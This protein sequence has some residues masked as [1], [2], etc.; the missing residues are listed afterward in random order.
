MRFKVLV[1]VIVLLLV[2][3]CATTPTKEG[4]RI[5]INY[6]ELMP[7]ISSIGVI[8]DVCIARDV[9]GNDNYYSIEDS[10]I[11]AFFML[12]AV[13][14]YLKQKGYQVNFQFSPF[15]GA[16]KLPSQIF[17]VSAQ[18]EGEV[19]YKFAPFYIF[20]SLNSN[21]AYKNALIRVISQVLHSIA[22]KNKSPSEILMSNRKIR[23]SLKI[24]ADQTNTDIIL[25]LIGHG[26]IVPKGKSIA[27]GVATGLA[28]AILTLGTVSVTYYDVSYLDTFAGLIDL[29]KGEILWSNSLRLK[30]G[31]LTG[32]DYYLKR[33]S[34]SILY[35]IPSKNE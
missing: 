33:W 2:S 4:I 21:E 6:E 7:K 10:K 22:Q 3:S 16:F 17:K 15:V 23:E 18:K 5:G 25:F 24:I 20:E 12:E 29:K 11:A 19:L 26:A 27:Q 34:E 9:T 14:A 31:N 13:K 32:R 8:N 35:H 28:T 30:K 1:M